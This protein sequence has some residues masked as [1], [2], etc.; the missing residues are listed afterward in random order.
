MSFIPKSEALKQPDGS[1]VVRVFHAHDRSTDVVFPYTP[2]APLLALEY[3]E[4][5]NAQR[6]TGPDSPATQAVLADYHA[7]QSNDTHEQLMEKAAA[8]LKPVTVTEINPA[9]EQGT[10]RVPAPDA[11]RQ[12]IAEALN[13]PVE[14]V[15]KL[16]TPPTSPTPTQVS[17][18][19]AEPPAPVAPTVTA[20]VEVPAPETQTEA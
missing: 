1:F 11:E 20:E 19:A 7:M 5:K 13:V 8:N 12:A 14:Q 9:G 4:F 6:V 3:A 15:H 16:P 18:P 17:G 2:E 10:S